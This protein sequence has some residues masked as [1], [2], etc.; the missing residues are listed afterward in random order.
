MTSIFKYAGL[1]AIVALAPMAASAVTVNAGDKVLEQGIIPAGDGSLTFSFDAGSDFNVNGFLV[2]GQ[3]FNMG[4]DLQLVTFDGPG[5]TNYTFTSILTGP[6]GLSNGERFIPGFFSFDEGD[7]ITF[8]FS[9][10]GN[11]DQVGI[12][13]NFEALPVPLPAGGLLLLS[14][15]GAGVVAS[16]RKKA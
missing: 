11:D 3:G 10:N 13:V 8:D 9:G 7:T 1:A 6:S 12:Q 2:G 14:A 4:S 5:G 16:R 15:L